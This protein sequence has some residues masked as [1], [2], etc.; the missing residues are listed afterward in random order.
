[1]K[2]FAALAAMALVLVPAHAAL[3]LTQ[4]DFADA[5][6]NAS[7]GHYFM[8]TI[9]VLLAALLIIVGMAR[10]TSQS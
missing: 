6:S 9:V 7:T 1:M 4:Q 5:V 10:G 8:S 2:H 3:A